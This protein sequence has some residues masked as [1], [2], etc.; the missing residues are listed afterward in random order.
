VP[1]RA[2]LGS[3]ETVVKELA[4]HER[5]RVHVCRAPA[6]VWNGAQVAVKII[7]HSAEDDVRIS[8][9]LS[10]RCV[11]ATHAPEHTVCVC[12]SHAYVAYLG[13]VLTTSAAC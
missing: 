8:R 4:S 1:G 7:S 9:E 11:C 13:L 3:C 5:A 10:L 12:V 6:G 2:C